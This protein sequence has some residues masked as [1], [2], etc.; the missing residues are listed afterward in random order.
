MKNSDNPIPN[1]VIPTLK[2]ISYIITAI[3]GWLSNEML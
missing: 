3:I 1:W 2:V